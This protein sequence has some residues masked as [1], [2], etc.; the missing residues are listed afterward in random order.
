MVRFRLL[1]E[2]DVRS[3]LTM[4]DLIETMASALKRFSAG[5]V[6]QPVRTV[7]S[8]YRD[9]AFFGSMPAFVRASESEPRANF[10]AVNSLGDEQAA[11]GEK[12]VTVFGANAARGL[13]THLA[14][15]VLLDPETGA[16]VAL[17]DGRYITEARTAAVS[18]V[19]SRLLARKGASSLAIIGSGVQARSH[20]EA[21]AGVHRLRHVSV[22]SPDADRRRRFVAD[23]ERS[24]PPPYALKA[25]DHAGEA[26][27]GA[28][29]ILL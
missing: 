26:A 15:I 16:L 12:L 25:V 20:L 6:V 7:I 11:L 14:T 27:V 29:L 19:S 21:L 23:R 3:V 24:G 9:D 18:A 28:D 4:D 2:A 22:W 10:G 5:R 1:T 13:H 17:L 8:V